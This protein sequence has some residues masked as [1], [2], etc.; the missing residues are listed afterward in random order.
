MTPNHALAKRHGISDYLA[1]A[2][3]A[4]TG[5]IYVET[6]RAL[7][8]SSPHVTSIASAAEARHALESWAAAPLDEIRF[9]RRIAEE[10]P[11]EGDGFAAGDGTRLKGVVLWAPFHVPAALFQT[12]LRL[13]ED[14]A[15]PA[16]WARVVGFRF[17]LQGKREGE[18]AA[19]VRSV[20]WVE[21]VVALAE[22]RGGLGWAFDVGVDTH[23]DGV[24]GLELVADMVDEVRRQEK[25]K[26]G[27]NEP[28]R[29]VIST[30][31]LTHAP[32][33]QT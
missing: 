13:A 1:A 16:L 20:A 28:V 3:P 12:Y 21:N 18:V 24:E 7:P 10:S 31:S 30:S 27:S 32:A 2:A 19:L 17:L 5:F 6:D 15:G 29:F 9:L 11:Q 25:K 14:E 23:R 4:P 8:A 33:S 22:G 26:G